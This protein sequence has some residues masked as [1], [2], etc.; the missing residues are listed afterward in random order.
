MKNLQD[1]IELKLVGRVPKQ[2][3]DPDINIKLENSNSEFQQ[4]VFKS[5]V[6]AY[7][8]AGLLK[9]NVMEKVKIAL[10]P[11]CKDLFSV[12]GSEQAKDVGLKQAQYYL[13][14]PGFAVDQ[15]KEAYDHW[16]EITQMASDYCVKQQNAPQP[17]GCEPQT[18]CI[19][20]D[21]AEVLS[22]II[23]VTLNIF[24]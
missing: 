11:D 10:T 13:S 19:P 1:A 5:H 16:D 4:Y 21:A 6:K 23:T 15:V 22:K 14:N 17:S 12:L 8:D 2:A 9:L 7:V 18:N 3:G 20:C 24:K